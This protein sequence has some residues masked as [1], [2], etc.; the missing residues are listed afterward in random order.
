M[1]ARMSNLEYHANGALGSTLLKAVLENAKKAKLVIDG[2]IKTEGKQIDIGKAFHTKVLEPYLFDH[3]FAVVSELNRRT[4]AGKE[5]FETFCMLSQ[6]KTIL[7]KEDMQIVDALVDKTLSLPSMRRWL[8]AGVAE[9]SFFGEIDGVQVKCRPDLLIKTSDGYI[10]VDL[11]SISD[12]ATPENFA[13]NSANFLYPLQ[14]ALYREVLEQNGKSVKSFLFAVA[15]KKEHSGAIWF[16]HDPVAV[17]FGKEL[18]QKAL[19]KYKWCLDNDQWLEGTFDFI[20]GGFSKISTAPLP[21]YAF[22]RF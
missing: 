17:D 5:A 11:K 8:D 2:K 9:A 13:K 19:F 15:S 6:G 1:T 21:N 16:E 3:E 12:E 20:Y 4:K 14:E 18:V 22:Y 7:T 10:V